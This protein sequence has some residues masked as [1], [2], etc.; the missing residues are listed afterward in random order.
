MAHNIVD[1]LPADEAGLSQSPP[2][3]PQNLLQAHPPPLDQ[4]RHHP[5]M[6]DYLPRPLAGV[7]LRLLRSIRCHPFSPAFP[8]LDPLLLLALIGA[9]IGDTS[10]RGALFAVGLSA[11]EGAPQVL[12]AG[13]AWM[14][15]EEYPAMPAALQAPSQVGMGSQNRPQDDV[16]LKNKIADLAPP[17]PVRQELKLPRD[18]YGKKPR[19]SLMM[20]IRP[21]CLVAAALVLSIRA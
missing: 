9:V 1:S 11:A 16:I 2:E 3:H 14:G 12:S 7:G 17:V 10:A 15:E 13:V 21:D 4:A 20:L 19:L 18:L 8:V 6:L 5:H